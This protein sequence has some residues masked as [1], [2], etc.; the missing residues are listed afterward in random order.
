[1]LA[2]LGNKLNSQLVIL[3]HKKIIVVRNPIY[4]FPTINKKTKS[5]PQALPFY[6]LEINFIIPYIFILFQFIIVIYYKTIVCAILLYYNML[7]HTSKIYVPNVN[8]Y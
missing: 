8:V 4:C 6:S 1:M 7:V 3:Y 5:A 2:L